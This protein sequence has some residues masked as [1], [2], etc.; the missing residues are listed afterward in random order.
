MNSRSW[1]YP[2][3]ASLAL[4]LASTGCTRANRSQVE[5]AVAE[6]STPVL[7]RKVTVTMR[8]S[9]VRASGTVEGHA[10]A[11][12]AFQ[13][14]GRAQSVPVHEGQRVAA[15]QLLAS[16]DPTDYRLSLDQALIA[17]RRTGDEFVRMQTLYDRK[18]LAPNDYEKFQAAEL[19]AVTQ[20]RIARKH[21]ADTKLYA[22]F[23]GLVARL[24][25]DA[26]ETVPPGAPVLTLVAI[27]PVKVKVGVPEASIHEVRPGSE[28]TIDLAAFG[29]KSHQGRVSLV[30]ISAEPVS[31]MYTVEIT[32]PNKDGA[33]LP[34]M[35]AEAAIQSDSLAP[36]V[37]LPPE[38]IVRDSDG[39]TLVYI[40]F[41]AERRVYARRVTVGSVA[42]REIEVLHG[43]DSGE[44]VVVG[45]QHR[46]R[47]GLDVEATEV[48]PQSAARLA[49]AEESR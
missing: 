28:A 14:G 40:Y 12:L 24:S 23:S 7:V 8:A 11:D 47:E 27:D 18:S 42:G 36:V 9:S 1:L 29:G 34:G 33:I 44:Y 30:G 45:G 37:T 38:A 35:I 49:S 2:A 26:Q 17:K 10:T 48:T 20:E 43:L 5:A 22:P 4:A 41:P 6:A 46:L 39:A 31:R 13:V 32:V 21:L 16:L 25:L 19:Q 15:G 3:V